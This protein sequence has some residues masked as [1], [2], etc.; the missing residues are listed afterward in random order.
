MLKIL[1]DSVSSIPKEVAQQE[2]IDIV[3]LYVNRDGVEYS[4]FDMDTDAFY[5]EIYDM[6]DNIPTSSQPSQQVLEDYFETAAKAGDSVLGIFLSSQLSGTYE[7]VIRAAR[8]VRSRNL[9]FQC[10]IVDSASCGYDE[11]LPIFAAVEARKE[12]KGLRECLDIVLDCMSRCRFAFAPES[13]TFLQK[14]GR[15]GRAA[16]LLG[17]LIKLSPVLAV[18]DGS[19]LVMGKVRTYKKAIDKM[20]DVFKKDME[21]HGLKNLVVHYI[22]NRKPAEDLAKNVI[23]PLLN[24]KVDVLPVSPVIGLHVGPAV[25]LAYECEEPLEEKL[26]EPRMSFATVL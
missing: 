5:S 12:G 13:L 16:A 3:T 21:A 24:R 26:T 15:I 25:G 4:D 18:K 19:V 23:E 10:A 8:A 22:G 14:G 9:D 11:S 2:D 7:G 1:T 6:L 20:V 17:N